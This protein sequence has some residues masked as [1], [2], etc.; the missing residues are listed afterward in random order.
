MFKRKL[1]VGALFAS[2]VA[3]ISVPAAA[4]IYV[5][6]APPAPRHEV[7]P[8]PRSGYV[9][10]PGYWDHRNGRHVWV[11]GHYER[12]RRGLYYHPSHWVERD[13][14]WYMQRSR[15]DKQRYAQGPGGD[16]DRDGVPNRVDR[17]KDGDGVPN[18]YDASP[19]NPNR[20]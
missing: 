4:E 9:W 8:A 2:T 19:N 11:K 13:G 20:R 1:L 17:D 5:R 15:W 6:V 7:I 14:R 3:C 10:A 18:K 16:R 12:E